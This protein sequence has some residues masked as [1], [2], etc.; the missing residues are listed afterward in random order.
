MDIL[1]Y[2]WKDINNP[3]VG[4]AEIITFEFARR[5]VREGH[6]V[7][8]FSRR[9]RRC[10]SQERIDG[11]KVI[12][13]GGLLS[14][15]FY[16]WRYYKSLVKKPDFV[17]DMLNTIF[18][19]TPLYVKQRKRIAYVN[20]MAKEVLFFE[21]NPIIANIGY[22][23][24]KV[25]FRSYRKTNFICYSESTLEDLVNTG[26]PRE[27]IRMFSL[28]LDHDRYFPG[29]K[30]ERPLFLCVSRLVKM[31]RVDLAIRAMAIVV[32][33]HPE[34][35]LA[36]VG[37][38][39][40]RKNLGDLRKKL[41]LEEKVFFVDEDIF[42]LKKAAK[43]QKVKLMQ[44]SWALVFPSVKEGW[45]MTVTECA[46][47]GT[48]SIVTDV[49]GLRD[50]V[51]R[52]ETGLVLSPNPTEEDLARAMFR[53]I[54]NQELRERLAKN[55]IDWSKNFDWDKSYNEFKTNILQ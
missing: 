28:G 29:V 30:H 11:I 43:D 31:K 16:G 27:N 25:Q 18:W 23:L 22:F 17:I 10:M 35:R 47:C 8:W 52:D 3:D 41:G 15:Y 53:I 32:R 20:Q 44:Q 6:Q 4:G 5:L 54:E 19:Q 51:K 48:P 2:N 26:I 50:S 33:K 55:C 1:I 9:F 39:Y 7:T 37:Y 13:R 45:G 42:F 36:I 49:T 46:A 21:L 40:L 12:R 24:E 34:A 38:G 14:T